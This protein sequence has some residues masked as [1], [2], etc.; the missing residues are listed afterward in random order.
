MH[1]VL[2]HHD[3]GAGL[4]DAIETITPGIGLAQMQHVT[5][6]ITTASDE[7]VDQQLLHFRPGWRG[8]FGISGEVTR[9]KS[10]L[11]ISA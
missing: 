8:F 1:K 9:A 6:L 10:D 5:V 11:R 3:A 4:R 7:L 2:L